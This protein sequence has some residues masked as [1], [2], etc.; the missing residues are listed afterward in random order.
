MST[1]RKSDADRIKD[2]EYG[3]MKALSLLLLTSAFL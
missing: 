3:P 1:K 2:R